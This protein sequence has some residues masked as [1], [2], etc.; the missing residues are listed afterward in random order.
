MDIITENKNGGNIE[1][2]RYTQ[3]EIENIGGKPTINQTSYATVYSVLDSDSSQYDFVLFPYVDGDYYVLMA[4]DGKPP[5]R[6]DYDRN[7]RDKRMDELKSP[8]TIVYNAVGGEEKSVEI[9][10]ESSDK[11]IEIFE[12]EYDYSDILYVEEKQ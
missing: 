4:V 9:W 3:K 5:V 2:R 10:A 1:I 12:Q 8:F 7:N 6:G 11:A